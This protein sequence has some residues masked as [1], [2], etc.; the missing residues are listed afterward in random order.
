MPL[1]IFHDVYDSIT[2][3]NPTPLGRA[4]AIVGNWGDI[5]NQRDFQSGALQGSDGRLS[6]RTRAAHHDFNLAHSLVASPTSGALGR[7]LGR[8]GCPFFGPLKAGG[9]GGSPGDDLAV[10]IGNRY[11]CVVKRRLNVSHSVRYV[12]LLLFC[13]GFLGLSRHSCLF[14]GLFE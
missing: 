7:R 5:S 1:L 9:T 12:P 4:T 13:S 14:N 10:L 3:L 11:N 8:E 2:G 6:A